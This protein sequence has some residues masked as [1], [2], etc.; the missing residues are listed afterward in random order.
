[1]S[2]AVQAGVI[3]STKA[4][5]SSTC[6][7]VLHHCWPFKHIYTC[8]YGNHCLPSLKGMAPPT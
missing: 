3:M 8:T 7:H 6:T 4:G 5:A 1:M 2:F